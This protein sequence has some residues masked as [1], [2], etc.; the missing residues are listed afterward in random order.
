MKN[1]PNIL[2]ISRII[3]APF[4]LYFV[5][6]QKNYLYFIIYIGVLQITDI[7]DGYFARKYKCA[8]HFGRKLDSYGDYF[9][10][11]VLLI[12]VCIFLFPFLTKYYYLT[13]L[14]IL[15]YVIPLVVGLI[16]LRR[17]P[18]LHLHTHKIVWAIFSL[19]YFLLY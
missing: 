16:F 3:L 15:S 5:F 7:L 14:I 10:Q 4:A 12:G 19:F 6:V 17:I 13:G 1:L 11:T 18:Q 9:L 8:S 2:T